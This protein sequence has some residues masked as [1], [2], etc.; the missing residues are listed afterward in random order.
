[1]KES[2]ECKEFREAWNNFLDQVAKALKIYSVLDWL[3]SKLE[4]FFKKSA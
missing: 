3:E 1:M 4:K 2:Q